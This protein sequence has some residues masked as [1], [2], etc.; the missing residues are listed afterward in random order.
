M[1][2]TALI[3]SHELACPVPVLPCRVAGCGEQHKTSEGNR[4][5]G[6]RHEGNRH[7]ENQ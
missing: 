3:P 2:A 1:L 4:H 7:E 6:N 5:E